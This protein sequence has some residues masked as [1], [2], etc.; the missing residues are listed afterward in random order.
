VASPR[1]TRRIRR[2]RDEIPIT[3]LLASYGYQVRDADRTQQFP[4][5]L[6]GDGHDGKPSA[7]VYPENNQWYCFACR[8]SRDAIQTVQEKEG[9]DFPHALDKLEHDYGLPPLPWEDGDN[10]DKPGNAVADI[11]D[12]PY[13]DPVRARCEK[14]LRAITTERSEPMLRVLKLWEAFDRARLLDDGGETEPL[15][16][17]LRVLKLPRE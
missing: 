16:S 9:L 6:H 14:I 4:C 5:D 8:V 11:L 10:E 13:V 1:T 17:L 15:K 7:R 12:A 3:R 2:I